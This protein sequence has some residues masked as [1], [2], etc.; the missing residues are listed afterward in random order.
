MKALSTKTSNHASSTSCDSHPQLL[1]DGLRS[2]RAGFQ[3]QQG[4]ISEHGEILLAFFA[5]GRHIPCEYIGATPC[6]FSL[7]LLDV[8]SDHH[9]ALAY[10]F[11]NHVYK[12][13]RMPFGKT[14]LGINIESHPTR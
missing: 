7:H 9:Q 1:Q 5:F 10:Q 12:H 3:A 14:L 8:Y 4:V 13:T 6:R 2:D 11:H